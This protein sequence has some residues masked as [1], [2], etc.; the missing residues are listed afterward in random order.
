MGIFEDCIDTGWV[1]SVG[2]YV[3]RFERD[4]AEF[5]G[6]M[7]AVAVV[8]GTAALQIALKLAGVENGDEVL[9]PALTFVATANAVA[10]CGADPSLCR[11]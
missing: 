4:L 2:S 5:T 10:Y 9:I 8:N 11:Q 3:D 1:S 6:A 7:C